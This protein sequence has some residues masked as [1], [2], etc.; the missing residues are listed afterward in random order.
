[1]AGVRAPETN[2][3]LLGK[4]AL[5]TGASSGLG[6]DFGREL[7][8]RGAALVLVA[9]RTEL[10][11]GVAQEIRSASGVAVKTL[12]ADLAEE[13]G[14]EGVAEALR[15]TD[16]D[17]LINNAG[18]GLYGESLKIPWT[19]ERTMLAVDV[20]AVAHAIKLFVPGMV[21][22]GYG[23]VL[24]LSSI[25]AFQPTP[26]YASYGGAKAF[27][28]AYSEAL[29][30]ELRGTGV[31]VSAISPGITKT[32]FLR[33][34][35]QQPTVYQRFAMMESAD[36]ARIGI[37]GMLRGKSSIVPGPLNALTIASGRFSPRALV[38]PLAAWMMRSNEPEH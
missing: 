33:V 9:R 6:V 18:L 16:I 37:A 21:A 28:L 24:N 1:M 34:S 8:A 3:S 26:Y 17:I 23:R 38:L 27:V 20:M 30:Y 2:G 35:G 15:D 36:V 13:S 32:E 4:T 11:E 22:R 5:V 14:R 31:T 10:L 12:V 7:A 25:A 29:N 19:K